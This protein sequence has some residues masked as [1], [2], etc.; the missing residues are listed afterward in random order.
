MSG[1]TAAPS[2][3]L[4]FG[5]AFDPPH[6][7]HVRL[8]Q[9]AI[10]AVRP[11]LVLVMPTGTSPHKAASLTPARLRKKMCRCFLQV[12]PCVRISGY[13]IAQKG[14]NYTID[15]VR[16]LRRQYPGAELVLT[17]G[18]DMLLHFDIW[19]DWQQLLQLVTICAQIR[20]DEDTAP[21]QQKAD[22]LQAMGGKVLLCAPLPV[23]LSSTQV[24]QAVAD[25]ANAAAYVP[26][27]AASVIQKYDLYRRLPSPCVLAKAVKA[28]LGKERWHHTLG[29]VRAARTLARRWGADVQAAT[30][31]AL[32]HDFLKESSKSHMLQIF[33]DNAIIKNNS[34]L[35]GLIPDD[36]ADRAPIIW[37]GYAAAIVVCSRF[38]IRRRDILSAIACH[39]CGK[40]G[41]STLDKVIYLADMISAERDFPGVDTLRKL[42]RG[43]A[44]TAMCHALRHTIEHVQSQGRAVDPDSLA[45]LQDLSPRK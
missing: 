26:A 8:L 19:R 4:L 41:M 15:T 43:D 9:N 17:M 33:A 20:D 35:A 18:S 34:P 14:K 23:E 16:W 32:L 39:T 1:K 30:T 24:R 21:L 10:A 45:A 36:I 11:D 13:E 44:D 3:V 25:G 7:G 2:C 22:E 38:G 29:V 40:A 28:Q 12:A 42:C 27:V 37:H 31:A 5:G 6:N